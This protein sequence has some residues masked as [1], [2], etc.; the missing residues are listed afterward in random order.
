MWRP[1]FR[2]APEIVG[3]SG[4]AGSKKRRN[5]AAQ[6]AQDLPPSPDNNSETHRIE[7]TGSDGGKFVG[8]C[9]RNWSRDFAIR[10]RRA[11]WACRVG[12]VLAWLPLQPFEGLEIEK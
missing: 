7:R 6:P 12:V 2:N 5:T 4:V 9:A 10:S 3:K 1:D 11:S 8:R